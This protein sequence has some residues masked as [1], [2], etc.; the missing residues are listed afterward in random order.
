MI[1]THAENGVARLHQCEIGR[2][3]RL[4]AGMRLHVGIVGAEELLRPI[5]GELLGD[6]DVLAA[7]VVALARDSLPRTCW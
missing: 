5:D 3:V 7:A 1:E 4:R 6:I 2:R